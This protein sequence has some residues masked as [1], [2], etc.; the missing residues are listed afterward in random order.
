MSQ[1]FWAG[2]R[3]GGSANR[4]QAQVEALGYRNTVTFDADGRTT[5]VVDGSRRMLKAFDSAGNLTTLMSQKLVG[6]TWQTFAQSR[7]VYDAVG[8]AATVV[9]TDGTNPVQTV[10]SSHDAL[11]R[12]A[13]QTV[14]GLASTFVY[15]AVEDLA[16]EQ[17]APNAPTT[18]SYDGSRNRVTKNAA[19]TL[20]TT[21]FDA[22]QRVA[23]IVTG[24]MV[25]TFAY[26]PDGNMTGQNAAG[27]LITFLWGNDGRMRNVVYADGTTS[28]YVYNGDGDRRAYVEPGGSLTTVVALGDDVLEERS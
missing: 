7:Y 17:N 9:H 13:S 23:S 3:D 15:N 14:D 28:T 4:G 8:Q 18:Y 24:A 10:T 26:D 2:D 6:G 16:S 19:G 11:G 27:S 12:I 22:A 21:V 25:T 1:P 20:T 5:T